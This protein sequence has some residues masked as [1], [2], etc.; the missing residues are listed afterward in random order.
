M[1]F[2]FLFDSQ[3]YPVEAQVEPPPFYR[4]DHKDLSTG[5]GTELAKAMAPH[6]S[7]LTWRI[8]WAEEPGRLQSMGSLGVGQGIKN[9]PMKKNA[10]KKN[11]CLGRP[12]KY[13]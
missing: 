10:K 8:P 11:G 9:I 6:S 1:A 5:L 13:L 4:V 3:K 12:Y 2:A 7:T